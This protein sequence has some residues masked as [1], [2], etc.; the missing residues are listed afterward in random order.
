MAFHSGGAATVRLAGL[1]VGGFL[2]FDLSPGHRLLQDLRALHGVLA[3]TGNHDFLADFDSVTRGAGTWGPPMRV[4]VPPE[5]VH[6]HL[7]APR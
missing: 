1:G 4:G 3:V 7:R 5:I 2:P 6:L